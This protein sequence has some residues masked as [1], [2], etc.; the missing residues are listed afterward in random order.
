MVIYLKIVICLARVE[1]VDSELSCKLVGFSE[2]KSQY[3][4]EFLET[5][6][7]FLFRYNVYLIAY[8]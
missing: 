5:L 4:N 1:N 3:L 2:Q 7:L 6:N 8:N